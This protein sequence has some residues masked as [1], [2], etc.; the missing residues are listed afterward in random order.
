MGGGNG[1]AK[2][3]SSKL[4]IFFLPFFFFDFTYLQELD[5]NLSP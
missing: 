4:I 3:L 2:E 1:P 5:D